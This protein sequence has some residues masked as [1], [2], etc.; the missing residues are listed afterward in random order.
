MQNRRSA[1]E[2]QL[3]YGA[4]RAC[5]DPAVTSDGHRPPGAGRPV[6]WMSTARPGHSGGTR[7]EGGWEQ[8]LRRAPAR[9]R[10]L[11]TEL[12]R[13]PAWVLHRALRATAR[14]AE[15]RALRSPRWLPP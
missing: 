11:A 13:R 5:R 12:D 9:C 3:R 15:I 2:N 8:A 1:A 7:A 4:S 14:W 6:R 10:G